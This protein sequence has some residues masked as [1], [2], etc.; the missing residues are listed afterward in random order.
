MQI[1]HNNKTVV[2]IT[3]L[4]S[5]LIGMSEVILNL[6]PRKKRGEEELLQ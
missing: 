1:I 5:L 2:N 3:S 6:V 4:I